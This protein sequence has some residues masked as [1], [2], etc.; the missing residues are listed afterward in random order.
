MYNRLISYIETFNILSLEQHSFKKSKSTATAI[1]TY[2]EYIQQALDN[3]LNV[4][5]IFWI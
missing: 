5:E 1:H 3:Q 4:I 2:V